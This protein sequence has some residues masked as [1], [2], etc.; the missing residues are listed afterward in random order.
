M[1]R[2]ECPR[3]PEVLDAVT[4]GQWPERA[5]EGLRQ[6]AA[7]CP[8][9]QDVAEVAHALQ[10]DHDVA[11]KDVQIPSASVVW[12]RA[13]MRARHEAARVAARPIS[14]VQAFAAAATVGVG[15]ALLGLVTPWVAEWFG[16]LTAAMSEFGPATEPDVGILSTLGLPF[17][18]PMLVIIAGCAMLASVAVYF[19]LSEE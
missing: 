9:C 13:E 10:A 4:S 3:E 19:I 17:N 15:L 14:I 7:E 2:T 18:M 8:L 5:D 11:M 1:K 16:R 12:W 6:H